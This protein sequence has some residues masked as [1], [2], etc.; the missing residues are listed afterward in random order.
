MAKIVLKNNYFEFKGEVKEQILE[1]VIE[2]KF[3]RPYAC[4]V[5]DKVETFFLE[6]KEMKPLVWF[7]YTDVFHLGSWTTET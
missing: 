6:T 7:G 1:K 3:A 5:T 2:T 4:I